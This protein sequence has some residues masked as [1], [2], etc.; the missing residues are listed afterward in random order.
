MPQDFAQ[1]SVA[2]ATALVACDGEPAA[3]ASAGEALAAAEAVR[4]ARPDV[5]IAV[6]VADR[7][8]PGAA[9]ARRLREIGRP[10]QTLV[11]AVAAAALP[12]GAPLHDLGIHRLR[13]L[14]L[15]ERVFALGAP[16]DQ[17]L[18][19]LDATPNNLPSRA[20]T[21]VGR[22]AEL[23]D[24]HGRL[25]QARLLTI[26]GPGGSGKTRLAA[27]LAADE[28][29]RRPD[30]AWWVELGDVADPGQVA[31]A[32]A[33]ALGVL[34]DPAQGTVALLRAQ[35]SSRRLLLCLDNCEHVLDAAADVA[36]ALFAGC[37]EVAIVA[38]SREPLGLTGELVWR[39]PPL[40]AREAH[41]LFV[42]RAAHVQ[43]GLALDADAGAAI[44]SMCVRLDGSPLALE[45]AAAWL[46]TL[47][48]RQI[49]AGLDDRFALLVRSPRDAIPRHASLLASMA[50]SH[51]LLD[52]G[53]RAVFRR[54]AVFP[55][56]FD[57]AAARAVCGEDADALGAL[58]RLVDKSLVVADGARYRLPE[59]IREYA[60]DRLRAA[61]ERRATSGRLLAHLLARVRDAA[62][63]R[64]T[65]KDAWRAALAPEHDNLR[66]AIEYGLAADDPEPA[67]ALVAELP[68]LWHMH[69]QGR[70]GLDFLRRAIA[71][72]PEDRSAVQARL[73]TG[74]ALVADT[75]GPLN[76]EYDAAQRAREL[77]AELG[78]ERLLSLCLSLA[79]VGRFY[80]D[81]GEACELALESERIAAQV[82][83]EFVIHAARALRGIVAH[84]RDDHDGAQALL[85]DAAERLT[86]RGDRGVA[87]S[88]LAF[89]SGSALLTGELGRARELAELSIATAAPLADHL[90][91]GMGRAALALALGA[92]GD[93]EGGV[94]A[95]APVR[96]LA[97]DVFLPEVNRALG[98]LHLW[99][100]EPDAAIARLAVE[101][102]STDG[103]RPT[104]LAVRALPA[105]A[106]AQRH[107]GAAEEAAATAARG[108]ALARERGM[109]AV[110]ADCLDEQGHLGEDAD[111]HHE[112]LAIRVR[113]GLRPGIVRSLEALAA[114]APDEQA[115][116]MRDAAAAA[117]AQL[118]LAP[119]A[120]PPDDAGA[121]MSLEE[122]AA[123]ASRARGSR[124]RPD[125]GWASLT[126]AELEVVRLA[127]DGLSNPEIGARLYMSRSTVKTH[128]SHV[129]AKLGVANRTELA[130][131]APDEQKRRP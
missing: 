32:V 10:G 51:E 17:P 124:R 73:L 93:L 127:V 33:A 91:I 111:R 95:L 24:L 55:A 46:R 26:T 131:Q 13:D 83:D 67:R 47:T 35:L 74:V 122:A 113:H 105:L 66:A 7:A 28:A 9:R 62:P 87:A 27:Q 98:V 21:F 44:D 80:T 88:A 99:A 78:D 109:P 3:F 117:R 104:Y 101:A 57:L 118:G 53:D 94:A 116:R 52:E 18:R 25:A 63:L 102:R 14:S 60:A 120:G 15:P 108:A 48:P 40:P 6:H 76:L 38:T 69:R 72:N 42:E 85:G 115:A 45:L 77:A 64:D 110:L 59:T 37:P 106:A 75:A 36:G 16:G 11:S 123:Y 29:G 86:A 100:G 50:W 23:A 12:A 81:F 22:E 68:W 90:R 19:S 65:D 92:A 121:V 82:G 43:P 20:T 125:H 114:Y 41:A 49:E 128:L 71:R 2:V 119:G 58:A 89:L 31:Q 112:A 130:A 126:P 5:V 34:V 129:Y 8:G 56:G 4:R 39:L 54:L 30:G 79:G 97:D 103:A 84:L 96:A 70:E 107:A 1:P 61:G